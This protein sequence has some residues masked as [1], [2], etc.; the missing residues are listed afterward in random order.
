MVDAIRLDGLCALAWWNL[1]Y[2]DEQLEGLALAARHSTAAALCWEGDIES[3]ANATILT[4]FHEAIELVPAIVVTGERLTGGALLPRL[5][6]RA[7]EQG[8]DFPRVEF[9][10]ALDSIT[11]E[12]SDEETPGYAVRMAGARIKLIGAPTAAT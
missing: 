7:R 6:E 8:E 11:E 3:W 2:A 10:E 12:L 1:A 9:M 5:A 4:W